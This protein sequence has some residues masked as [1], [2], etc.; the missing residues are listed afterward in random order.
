MNHRL[1]PVN[2]YRTHRQQQLGTDGLL[3]GAQLSDCG[4]YRELLW[5]RWGRDSEP[6]VSWVMLNPS[7][8]DG[9]AD[10]HTIRRCVGYARRWGFGGIEVRN[11]FTW[12]ATDPTELVTQGR[13]GVDVVGPGGDLA[14]QVL[15]QAHDT[16]PLILAAWGT[17]GSLMARSTRV[18]A[19]LQRCPVYALKLTAAG[20][21]VHPARQPNDITLA[22]LV[23]LNDAARTVG[24]PQP[25]PMPP[26]R[27]TP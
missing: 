16:P 12:R 22:D 27:L 25:P 15:A 10:D 4:R 9:V 17:A 2:P 6:A 26:L 18:L 1:P 14:I 5:R 23:P 7:T 24:P 3:R 13:A 19:M 20:C 8:A 21:P 11:L